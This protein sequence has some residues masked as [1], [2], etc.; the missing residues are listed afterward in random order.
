MTL[1]G[2]SSVDPDG[3][4]LRHRIKNCKSVDGELLYREIPE[5]A[6]VCPDCYAGNFVLGAIDWSKRRGRNLFRLK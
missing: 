1:K 2:Y 3:R 6:D 4:V 5:S